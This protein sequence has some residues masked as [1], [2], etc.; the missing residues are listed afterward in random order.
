VAKRSTASSHGVGRA[1]TNERGEVPAV[2]ELTPHMR[3]NSKAF[4]VVREPPA[5]RSLEPHPAASRPERGG[6]GG[7][8]TERDDR[9]ECVTHARE[10]KKHSYP[11]SLIVCALTGA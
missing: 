4:E 2:F 5:D 10:M 9:D 3:R 1:Q 7:A 8:R 6:R 11:E